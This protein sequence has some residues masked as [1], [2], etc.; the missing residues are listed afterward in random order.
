RLV[1]NS[2]I[3]IDPGGASREFVSSA[4]VGSIQR[5]RCSAT[6]D[7]CR[8]PNQLGYPGKAFR[9]AG[10]ALCGAAEDDDPMAACR[11]APVL[12]ME[13]STWPT[14]DSG[15]VTGTDPQDGRGESGV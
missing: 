13:V 15:R 14:E 8:N 4:A 9:M 6:A 5:A 12:A 10:C 7:R 3:R 2:P 11:V 1:G